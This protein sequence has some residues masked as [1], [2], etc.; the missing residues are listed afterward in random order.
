MHA[1]K[2][3]ITL[4]SSSDLL[5]NQN[6]LTIRQGHQNQTSNDI[7]II[8]LCKCAYKKNLSNKDTF[9]KNMKGVQAKKD[10]LNWNAKVKSLSI[11]LC[12]FRLSIKSYNSQWTSWEFIK[13]PMVK[14]QS[15]DINFKSKY[16]HLSCKQN[17][18]M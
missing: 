14:C 8:N 15:K 9:R 6:F 4:L 11:Y 7:M 5:F 13:G 3:K 18:L 12:I 17:I 16:Y 10:R 1:M 2:I